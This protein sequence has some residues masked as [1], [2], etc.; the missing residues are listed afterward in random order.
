MT[1]IISTPTTTSTTSDSTTPARRD[2]ER[3]LRI[4]LR[5]NA[6]SSFV[7]GIVLA[8]VPDRVDQ[9]LDT[10]HPGWV[11]VV[12]LALLPLAAFYAWVSSASLTALR[13]FT[14]EIAIADVAW[15]V[16]SI[17]TVLLGWYST[18]GAVAVLAVAAL[19]DTFALLQ[20]RGWRR[21]RSTR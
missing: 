4:V 16:A 2:H 20:W 8:V 5:V 21:I 7:A 10:G 11:R 12:G 14:P 9:V 13:R 18:G 1:D 19:I 6:V 3:Q 15:V 17:V